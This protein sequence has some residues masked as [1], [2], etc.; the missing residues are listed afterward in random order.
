MFNLLRCYDFKNDYNIDE[1]IQR[2]IA[3]DFEELVSLRHFIMSK[4][5]YFTGDALQNFISS[6]L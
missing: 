5:V 4:T 6:T 3:L 2:I 1:I